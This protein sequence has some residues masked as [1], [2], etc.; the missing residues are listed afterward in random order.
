LLFNYAEKYFDK[1]YEEM[2]GYPL[3]GRIM[4]ASIKIIRSQLCTGQ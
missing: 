4:G 3:P 2:Y 1:K